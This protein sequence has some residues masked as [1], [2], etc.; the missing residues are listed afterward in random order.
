LA[1]ATAGEASLAAAEHLMQVFGG[2]GFTWDNPAHLYLKR[3]KADRLRWGHPD[4]HYAALADLLG[5]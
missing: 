1:A 5:I 3:A 4:V 2:V